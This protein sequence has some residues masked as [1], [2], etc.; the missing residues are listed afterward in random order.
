MDLLIPFFETLDVAAL[1]IVVGSFVLIFRFKQG[2]LRT[3]AVA[4]AAGLFY[5][6]VLLA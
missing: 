3:L 6:L 4:M 1:V 5:H 2:M